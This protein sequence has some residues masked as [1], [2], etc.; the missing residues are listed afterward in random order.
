MNRKQE[1]RQNPDLKV[2][3]NSN[4]N[5]YFV[6]NKATGPYTRVPLRITLRSLW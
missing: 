6:I 1:A 2:G 4:L 5:S 3:W